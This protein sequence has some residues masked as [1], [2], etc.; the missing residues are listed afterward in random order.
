MKLAIPAKAR[1]TWAFAIGLSRDLEAS[2]ITSWSSGWY[3]CLE[4][5]SFSACREIC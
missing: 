1:K 4:D 5:D 2:I 3:S